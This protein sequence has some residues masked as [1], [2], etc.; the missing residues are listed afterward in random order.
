M[1]DLTPEQADVLLHTLGLTEPGSRSTRNLFVTGKGDPRLA[2]LEALVAAGL[3]RETRAPGFLAEGDRVFKATALGQAHALSI[4]P[5][6]PKLT[7]SQER[8]RRWLEG[9]GDF[10]SFRDYILGGYD[11]G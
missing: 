7:R 6:P 5:K 10:M 1:P 4:Q 9:P 11:C 8:Y 3:M 2:D